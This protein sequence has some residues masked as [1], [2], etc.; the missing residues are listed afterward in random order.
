MPPVVA[1]S[2]SQDN[3]DIIK[4]PSRKQQPS[5][6]APSSQEPKEGDEDY[7]APPQVPRQVKEEAY[8]ASSVVSQ[9]TQAS[10]PT[11]A[12]KVPRKRPRSLLHDPKE[13]EQEE[14]EEDVPPH[15]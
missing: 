11:V 10:R 6:Q 2:S 8:M 15:H 13:E 7:E 3:E 12:Q 9:M 5:S 1:D 4:P 14:E